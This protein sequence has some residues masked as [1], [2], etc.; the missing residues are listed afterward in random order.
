MKT[1]A[2]TG[3]SG[4]VGA[5]VARRFADAGW[6]VR[7]LVHSR[8][9]PPE[10]EEAGVTAMRG[11]LNDPASLAELAAGADAVVH[12]AALI[13]AR[14][15]Q[16]F[17]TVNRDGARNLGQAA[18][19]ANARM[20][21]ISSLAAR[22]PELSDY[23]ASK[24]AGEAA[25]AAIGGLRWDTIRPPAVYGEGDPET[26]K[27]LRWIARGLAPVPAGPVARLS[28]IH[29]SDLAGA[30]LAWAERGDATQMVYEVD[31]GCA[32][33]R[34]WPEIVGVAAAALGVRPIVFAAPAPLLVAGAAAYEGLARAFGRTP[35]VTA[36]KARELCWPDWR[37]APEPFQARFGWRPE[38][39]LETGLRETL[40]WY[41][42]AGWL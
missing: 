2:L 36:G 16:D 29:V 38:R 15:P 6:R 22:Q 19:G 30:A 32:G 37:C 4:F 33:G 34:S 10:L 40:D 27:L 7:A 1:L 26:L 14:R 42:K 5:A 11:G 31:D 28:L 24:A 25:V 9:L 21:F 35:M 41:R 12:C 18:S 3:A 17:F 23:A 8:P 20:L 13:K 39:D